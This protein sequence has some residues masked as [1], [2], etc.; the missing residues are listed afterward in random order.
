MR[1]TES[2]PQRNH[3]T[4]IPQ[5]ITRRIIDSWCVTPTQRESSRS[6]RYESK[7]EL[8]DSKRKY[9]DVD[10]VDEKS[11][12]A[13]EHDESGCETRHESRG[14]HGHEHE[15]V[16]EREEVQWTMQTL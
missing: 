15:D 1:M 13:R 5:E 9:K 7:T 14:N 12:G 3:E 16:F 2:M 8:Q 11:G 10:Y 6:R 4:S